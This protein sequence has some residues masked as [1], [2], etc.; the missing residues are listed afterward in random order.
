MGTYIRL[1]ANFCAENLQ[2]GKQQHDIFKVM[3]EENLQPKI[4]YA[5]SL[6]FKI[7]GEI[8]NFSEKQKLKEFINTKPTLIEMLKGLL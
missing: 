5:T 6:S 8:K 2:A 3:K 7:E 4:L 1:S